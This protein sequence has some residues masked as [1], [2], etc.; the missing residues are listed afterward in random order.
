M[1]VFQSSYIHQIR[2]GEYNLLRGILALRFTNFVK[3]NFVKSYRRLQVSVHMRDKNI[4]CRPIKI[5][6]FDNQTSK[7]TRSLWN[8]LAPLHKHLKGSTVDQQRV[9]RVFCVWSFENENENE[10]FS[11]RCLLNSAQKTGIS[12]RESC[13]FYLGR[14]VFKFFS[15]SV[16][17]VTFRFFLLFFLDKSFTLAK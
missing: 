9:P 1:S 11:S 6:S 15:F 10:C 5:Q 4:F 12:K 14:G 2:L 8:V 17:L 7:F 13:V 3:F 16:C